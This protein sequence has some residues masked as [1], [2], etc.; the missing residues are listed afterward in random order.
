MTG[1]QGSELVEKAHSQASWALI[2]RRRVAAAE[3][4]GEPVSRSKLKWGRDASRLATIQQ[5]Y[6]YSVQD[7]KLQG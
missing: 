5:S 7:A 1:S 4:A 6:G 3:P 2:T